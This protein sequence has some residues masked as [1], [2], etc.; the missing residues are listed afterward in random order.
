MNYPFQLNEWPHIGPGF[1]TWNK[2]NV[3]SCYR[4]WYKN[5]FLVKSK[6]KNSLNL[7]FS[8]YDLKSYKCNKSAA[9]PT[10]LP[11]ILPNL[12]GVVSTMPWWWCYKVYLSESPFLIRWVSIV[13]FHDPTLGIGKVFGQIS[14]VIKWNYQ[15]LGPHQVTVRQKLGIILVIKWFKN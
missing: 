9:L 7:Y 14:T 4:F 13:E 1:C 10:G 8:F 15:I 2:T 11:L 12:I 6:T 3:K 5:C